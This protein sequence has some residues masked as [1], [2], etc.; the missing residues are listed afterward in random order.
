M[1]W[2][3]RSFGLAVIL[4]LLAWSFLYSFNEIESIA[5]GSS[6]Q[7]M[8]S[9][10][11]AADPFG[12][13]SVVASSDDGQEP[14]YLAFIGGIPSG[15]YRVADLPGSN[16]WDYGERGGRTPAAPSISDGNPVDE[17]VEVIDGP[18]V[19]GAESTD[20]EDDSE[21][22]VSERNHPEL[23]SIRPGLYATRFGVENCEYELRRIMNDN[24]EHVIGHDQIQKGRLLVTIN[25]I[26]PDSFVATRSCGEWSPWS[27]LA[28]PLTMAGNGDYWIGDLALGIWDVPTGCYW[29]KVV[30]FRGAL[31][32][33]VEEAGTGPD[34]LTIDRFTLGV[35]VRTCGHSPMTLNPQLLPVEPP[36]ADLDAAADAAHRS[37]VRTDPEVRRRR[38]R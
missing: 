2:F 16:D 35:R 15:R 12:D 19:S 6:D 17:T 37:P 9:S 32:L 5:D 21:P 25:E 29:E 1:R 30:G 10:T 20:V 23:P 7:H 13:D 3:L 22:E 14:E 18:Y 11:A 26:E 24:R 36:P 33:D 28:E 38:R 8:E 31:L 4:G 34:P 27:P